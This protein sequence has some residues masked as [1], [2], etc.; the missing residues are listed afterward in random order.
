M[1]EISAY[2]RAAPDYPWAALILPVATVPLLIGDAA[3]DHG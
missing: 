3:A 2:P 1:G